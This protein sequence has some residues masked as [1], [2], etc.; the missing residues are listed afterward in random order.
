MR[1]EGSY[2]SVCRGEGEE[3]NE[4]ERERNIERVNGL[5]HAFVVAF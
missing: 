2:T 5:M 3:K 4:R 1:R